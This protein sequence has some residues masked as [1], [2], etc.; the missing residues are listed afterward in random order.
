[1]SQNI[2]SFVLFESVHPV[3]AEILCIGK[4]GL[5]LDWQF[6]TVCTVVS[7]CLFYTHS[8]LKI[9]I[10]IVVGAAVV[11]TKIFKKANNC[12]NACYNRYKITQKF[13]SNGLT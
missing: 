1:M 7:F 2:Y 4:G 11:V 10:P 5:R 13:L 6:S 12:S 8:P 3:Y 9:N